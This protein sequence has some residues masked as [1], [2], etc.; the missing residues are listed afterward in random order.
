M[1][2]KSSDDGISYFRSRSKQNVLALAISFDDG[3]AAGA[4]LTSEEAHLRGDCAARN[5][6]S[7]AVALQPS[8]LL[9]RTDLV[10]MA[11]M[12]GLTPAVDVTCFFRP[13]HR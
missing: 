3:T 9:P 11:N 2:G 13:L 5:L 8:Q 4:A 1:Y 12:M 7:A 10:A 6:V